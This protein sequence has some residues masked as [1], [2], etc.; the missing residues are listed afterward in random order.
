MSDFAKRLRTANLKRLPLFKNPKGETQHT[1][2]DWLVEDWLVATMGEVGEA[3]NVIKKYRRDDFKTTEDFRIELGKELADVVI[4]FDFVQYSFF[5]GDF[6][7]LQIPDEDVVLK[8]RS[9]LSLAA[10]GLSMYKRGDDVIGSA[11]TGVDF[12]FNSARFV[13]AI[14]LVADHVGIDL[15]WAITN[16][17]NRFI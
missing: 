12:G 17:F 10:T 9:H 1:G 5:Q 8:S 16:K 13:L 2:N 6:R 3:L 15:E 11:Q 7:L 4:Y 14:W